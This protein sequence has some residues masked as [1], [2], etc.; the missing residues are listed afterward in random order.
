MIAEIAIFLIGLGTVSYFQVQ[1]L[2]NQQKRKDVF[3]YLILMATAGLIGALLI[4]GVKV[5]SPAVPIRKL[6]EPIAKM[7][8]QKS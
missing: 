7:I 1:H 8:L 5:P 4:A 2:L 3:F 6:F